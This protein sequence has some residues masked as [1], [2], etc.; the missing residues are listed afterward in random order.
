MRKCWLYM[1]A[2]CRVSRDSGRS[3]ETCNSIQAL[4]WHLF[5]AQNSLAACRLIL[6]D[7]SKD[8]K[9]VATIVSKPQLNTSYRCQKLVVTGGICASIQQSTCCSV[10][11]VA[12][13]HH[14]VVQVCLIQPVVDQRLVQELCLTVLL[15]W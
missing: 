4:T 11:E 3:V 7:T 10:D 14:D 6:Y 2:H 8:D 15:P 1:Y 12:S 13:F 9:N 5:K